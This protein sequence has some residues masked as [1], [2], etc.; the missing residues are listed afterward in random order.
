[1]YTPTLNDLK[2]LSKMF[3]SIIHETTLRCHLVKKFAPSG[4]ENHFNATF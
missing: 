4:F 3:I 1:M 2:P